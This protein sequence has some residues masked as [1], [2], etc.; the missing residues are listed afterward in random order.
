MN[1]KAPTPSAVC[2]SPGLLC[3]VARRMGIDTQH[4]AI[5]FVLHNSVVRRAEGFAA[6]ARIEIH[7]GSKTIIATLF[8]TVGDHLGEGEIGLSEAAWRRLGVQEGETVTVTHP[9]PLES[10]SSVRRKIFGEHIDGKELKAILGDI[11]TGRYSDIQLSAFITACSAR[12]LARDEVIG[13]TRAMIEVGEK[14][15]WEHHPIAD[16]HSV[17]GLPGNRTTPVIVPIVACAGLTMP[18]TSSRAIT[19]PAGTAD[20]M[21]TLAPVNLTLAKMR[22]VVEQV[23]GC[24]AW[25]GTVKLSPADD[26]LIRIERA[27]DID[28]EGQLVASVLSKKIAAGA[29]HVII[30]IPVG[31][32][33]KVR[34]QK[35]AKLLSDSLADVARTF[36]VEA[37]AV[38]SDGSQPVGRG[39]GPAL[40]AHDV[41][42]VLQNEAGAPQD[43][44]E[45]S[46]A[47][48]GGLIELAGKAKAGEGVPLAAE[49]LADGRAWKKFQNICE[50][51]G[52]MRTPPRARHHRPIVAARDGVITD[53]DNRRL[54]R[55][56][57]LAGAPDSKAAGLELHVRLGDHVKKGEPLFTLHAET[58][59]EF[60]YALDYTANKARDVITIGA[61]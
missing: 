47:L 53:I 12:V 49:I 8:E 30:D 1:D 38:V 36:G 37:R 39:M 21:E 3:L 59:G 22:S 51:Q 50:A 52:G 4:E 41:L 27:L 60:N 42:A 26:I 15:T 5:A 28:S 43:L 10:M 6:Q 9:Q 56:A 25:G 46:L 13:L 17:G 24:I 33:A 44:R 11:A 40:E 31:A 57:K 48:A 58:P 35:S 54:S 18:K 20:T 19:S 7:H 23:G 45:R 61:R 34:S 55:I 16:K 29:T 32:T 2:E 14:L